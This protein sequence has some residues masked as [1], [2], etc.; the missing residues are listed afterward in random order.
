[1]N[2][3]IIDDEKIDLEIA[4]TFL[5]FYIK[6][7]WANYEPL[8]HIETFYTAKDFIQVFSAGL[9]QLVILGDSMRKLAD[10]IRARGD[11]D[12]KI[13]FLKLSD[14]YDN[15]GGGIDCEYRHC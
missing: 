13:I 11:Y 3:A 6:K 14:N 4:E 15:G 2:I 8:I 7:F 12:V 10:F 5:H 9:Y 1:M